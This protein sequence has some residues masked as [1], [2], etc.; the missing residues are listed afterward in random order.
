MPNNYICTEAEYVKKI[1]VGGEGLIQVVLPYTPEGDKLPDYVA[2]HDA[3]A[4]VEE[5]KES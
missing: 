2:I 1:L 4:A 5:P 3:I